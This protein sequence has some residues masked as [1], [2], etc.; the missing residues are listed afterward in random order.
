MNRHHDPNRRRCSLLGERPTGPGRRT[1]PGLAPV[2]RA[3]AVPV[4]CL[5]LPAVA[6]CRCRHG[7]RGQTTIRRP[8][9]RHSPC[10]PTGSS[11]VT[12]GLP[13]RTCATRSRSIRRGCRTTTRPVTI[14]APSE[15]L[16]TGP[17]SG[18]SCGSRGSTRARGSGSTARS[19]VSPPGAGCPRSST[20]RPSCVGTRTTLLP[21]ECTS[22]RRA[23]I[24]RIRTCGGCQASSARSPCSAARPVASTTCSSMPTT[25]TGRAGERCGWSRV[26]RRRST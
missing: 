1:R 26:S 13:T 16:T 3:P 6:A 15:S 8:V 14:A 18:S 7:F 23:A 5:V 17:A 24:S 22:G 9:G 12:A 20:S 19:W 25:T 21:Y 10:L 4:R 2:E 11:P